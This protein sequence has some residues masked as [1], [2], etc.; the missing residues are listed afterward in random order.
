MVNGYLPLLQRHIGVDV[1]LIV[2]PGSSKDGWYYKEG[3]K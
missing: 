3:R 2:V 1:L